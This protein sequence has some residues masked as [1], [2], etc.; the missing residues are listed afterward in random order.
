MDQLGR[1]LVQRAE[2]LGRGAEA[3]VDIVQV[4]SE[5]LVES[6]QLLEDG[7]PCGQAGACD[8][9]ALACRGRHA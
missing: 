4:D 2:P 5:R 3:V 6:P 8:G 9:G 1:G 7:A